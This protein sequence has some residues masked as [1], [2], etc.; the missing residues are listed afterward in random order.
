VPKFVTFRDI[1]ERLALDDD[2]ANAMLATVYDIYAD[3][4]TPFFAGISFALFESWKWALTVSLHLTTKCV[5]NMRLEFE[6]NSP[7]FASQHAI[8]DT[9]SDQEKFAEHLNNGIKSAQAGDRKAARQSLMSALDI[10]PR[11]ENAWLW[12]ASIS[13]YPE[14]LL[15]FLNNVL[16]INPQN[17]RALQWSASTKLLLSKTLVQ[18]GVDAHESGRPEFAVQC[19]EQALGHDAHN[20]TAWS[21]LAK[22]SENEE[23]RLDCYRRVIEIDPDDET[24]KAALREQESKSRSVLLNQAA[25][26]VLEGNSS[27]A[28]EFLAV[29]S[30]RWP[31]NVNALVLRAHLAGSFETK[32]TAWNA[33]LDADPTN[34]LA[35]SMLESLNWLRRSAAEAKDVNLENFKLRAEA[36]VSRTAVVE[37]TAVADIEDTFAEADTANYGQ[38]EL[39]VE[40]V[41]A[42]EAL[43]ADYEEVDYREV[44]Q[45]NGDAGESDPFASV[46]QE[47]HAEAEYEEPDSRPR[48]LVIEN[49]PTARRLMAGKL[50]SSGYKV[51]CAES[52][53]E[54]VEI[55]ISERPSLVLADISIQGMDGYAICRTLR[56]HDETQDIPVVLIAGKDGWYE[57]DLGTAAGASGFITKPFGPESLMKTVEQYIR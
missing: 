21:W 22:L 52:A 57:E 36:T 34:A 46:A 48:I 24:A 20:A 40:A 39:H 17:E 44:E 13:E 43:P 6:R 47:I 33:V 16:D 41:E 53:R 5:T 55:A 19:F 38:A 45:S 8:A 42:V 49:N 1:A 3:K 56:D 14:E 9:V 29:V 7:A 28:S 23:R 26:Y 51:F 11:N 32:E 12:L 35:S 27:A 10:D 18:R 4:S 2:R 30:E 31:D 54:S 25:K 50:E 15:V 37:A